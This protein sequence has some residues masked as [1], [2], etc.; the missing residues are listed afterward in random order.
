MKRAIPIVIVALALASNAQAQAKWFRG[1]THTHTLNSDGDSPPDSVARWYR[2]HGYQFLFITD[3]E[4]QTDPVPLNEKFGVPGKFLL[5]VGQEV[6]QRVADSTHYRG[7]RQAHINSLGANAVVLPQGER[8]LARGITMRQGYA[9]NVARIRAAGGIPQINHPNFVWSVRLQDLID[10]PDSV[11]LE[12][13]NAHTGVNNDGDGDSPST[14]ALW[15]SLLTRGKTIFG[16][17]DDDAHSF[18]PENADS[19]ELT[20]PGRAWIV[21]RA[22]TLTPNA[23]LGAIRRGD[24]Y[25]STGVTLDSLVTSRAEL[26]LSMTSRQETR[27][28]TEFIGSGGRVLSRV[29]GNRASYQVRGDEGYVR[30]RVTDSNGK[31]AW[32]QAVRVTR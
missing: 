25:A 29:R 22:D 28:L 18:R 31:R 15:D 32:T 4:K 2:D 7:T 9:D 20:R 24:F 5:V 6:T 3:H 17:A 8:G 14:E 27:F 11:L 13:A 19:H 21:V 12:V 10:L 26:R 30:A 23:I 1:N 16:V